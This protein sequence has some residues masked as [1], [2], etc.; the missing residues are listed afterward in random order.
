MAKARPA[1]GPLHGESPGPGPV[2]R[3][4]VLGD[5]SAAGFGAPDH[6]TALAG[7][8]ATALAADL[9]RTV[10]WRVAARGGATAR[11]VTALLPRLT[12]QATGWRPDLV[13][14]AVG[15]NDTTRLRR[16]TAFQRDILRLVTALHATLTTPPGTALKPSHTEL[17]NSPKTHAIDATSA[18]TASPADNAGTAGGEAETGGR[19]GGGGGG[20]GRSGGGGGGEGW[21]G[22]K[23]WSEDGAWSGEKRWSGG[24]GGAPAVVPV[25][26]SG[27]PPVHRF[28]VLPAPARWLFGSHAR[29]L[30]RRLAAAA[31]ELPGTHHLPVGDIPMDQP[32]LFASDGF[33]PAPPAYQIWARLLARQAAPL[34]A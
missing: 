25:L 24:G 31:A 22:D 15:V 2:L 21:S 12:D 8:L 5:S 23:G 4:A 20:E 28:P 18:A 33:H 6:A 34:L 26:L 13:V 30:D 29:R 10:S 32:G 7:Q 17:N 16:P 9:S 3:L 19:S 14:V 11:T 1:G 27:L